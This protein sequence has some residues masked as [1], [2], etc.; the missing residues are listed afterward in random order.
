MQ[1]VSLLAQR[2][3][4]TCHHPQLVASLMDMPVQKARNAPQ[5]MVGLKQIAQLIVPRKYFL[6]YAMTNLV[7]LM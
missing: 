3:R 7:L 6:Q 2:R 5:L 4:R 1:K